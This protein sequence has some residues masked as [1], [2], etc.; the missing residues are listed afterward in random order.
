MES[1][2]KSKL[3]LDVGC[4]TNKNVGFIGMDKRKVE[5]VDIVHDAEVIPWPLDDGACGVIIM[6]HLIEHISPK[7]TID[8]IDECWRILELDGALMISTPYGGSFRYF[9]DPTHCNPWVEATPEYFDPTRPLYQVY[10]PRPWK[11]E[12]LYWNPYG[13]LELAMRK[14]KEGNNVIEK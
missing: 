2:I 7:L 6:S 3:F 14:I 4:S 9:Q 1:N 10:K 5:G 8:V 12:K 13:D 11:I